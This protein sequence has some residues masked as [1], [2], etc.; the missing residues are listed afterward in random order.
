MSSFQRKALDLWYLRKR[1]AGSARFI[2]EKKQMGIGSG[3]LESDFL[4][5]GE[6]N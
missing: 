4:L 2:E 5:Q 6:N 1:V 3:I